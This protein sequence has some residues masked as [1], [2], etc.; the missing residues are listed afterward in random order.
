MR[1]Q[2]HPWHSVYTSL[3]HHPKNKELLW[4][5]FSNAL[6][7][8]LACSLFTLNEKAA[9]CAESSRPR[10]LSGHLIP[11][12]YFLYRLVL[13]CLGLKTPNLPCSS[14]LRFTDFLPSL[15]LFPSCPSHS[16]LSRSLRISLSSSI[17]YSFITQERG[18]VCVYK[19]VNGFVSPQN[20]SKPSSPSIDYPID[21]IIT[22]RQ[23]KTNRRNIP[24]WLTASSLT[25][26]QSGL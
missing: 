14:T 20:Y 8:S 22:L 25:S 3:T 6:S 9:R 4:R 16:P 10:T 15:Y 5:G 24:Y 21:C 13:A 1:L 11:I 7:L 26:A 23:K 19:A 17:N 2:P 18:S 12:R